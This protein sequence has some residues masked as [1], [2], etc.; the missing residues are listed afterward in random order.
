MTLAAQLYFDALVV[1]RG[2]PAS[3][4]AVLASLPT[5]CDEWTREGTDK[6]LLWVSADGVTGE[7][8]E[9]WR[10]GIEERVTER[11]TT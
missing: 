8:V 6:L 4:D 11:I 2:D 1:V 7:A 10:E 9:A 3:L 5:W